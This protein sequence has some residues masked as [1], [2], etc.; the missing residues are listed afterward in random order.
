MIKNYNK[1]INSVNEVDSSLYP[2]NL[3]GNKTTNSISFSLDTI[4]N[5]SQNSA[6][7]T[8]EFINNILGRYK[9]ILEIEDIIHKMTISFDSD[10]IEVIGL[11]KKEE[12]HKH[13]YDFNCILIRN[14]SDNSIYI[15][16]LDVTNLNNYTF[17]F[18]KKDIE[19]RSFPNWLKKR[20]PNTP[21]EEITYINCSNGISLGS[22]IKKLTNLNN[23]ENLINLKDLYCNNNEITSL[24]GIEKLI[25]LEVLSCYDNRLTNLNGIENLTNLKILHC[26]YNQLTNLDEIRYLIN[27]EELYFD[28]NLFTKHYEDYLTNYC[29]TNNILY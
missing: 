21:Y 28:N 6:K 23:I 3:P 9:R 13:V 18:V 8:A 25:K 11:F 10:S 15:F 12:Y 2:S 5:L 29:I 26:S 4:F 22:R 27:L 24:D 1:Y 16:N 14:I 17:K 19:D 20:Y 7:K